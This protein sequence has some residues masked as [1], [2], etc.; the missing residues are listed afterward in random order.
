ME[1]QKVRPLKTTQCTMS[2]VTFEKKMATV[3]ANRCISYTFVKRKTGHLS[4]SS[5]FLL[6]HLN[7]E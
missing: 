3:S 6:R 4:I 2:F 5:I 7:N 1:E